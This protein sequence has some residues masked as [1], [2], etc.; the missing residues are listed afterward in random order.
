MDLGPKPR[1]SNCR[2][3]TMPCCLAASSQARLLRVSDSCPTLLCQESGAPKSPPCSLVPMRSVLVTGA[4][5]GIGRAT[6]LRLDGSGW[7]VF[8]GVRK[9]ADAESLRQEASPN[10][11]PVILDV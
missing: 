7:Q 5:T 11:V 6:A 4:S 8:A 10:L 1:A 3:V 2:R 9:E